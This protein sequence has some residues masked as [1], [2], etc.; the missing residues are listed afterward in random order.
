M[1]PPME[2]DPRL[3]NRALWL[4]MD[5]PGWPLIMTLAR[6]FPAAT[7]EELEAIQEEVKVSTGLAC[8]EIQRVIGENYGRECTTEACDSVRALLPWIE[9]GNLEL[10]VG[11]TIVNF[12]R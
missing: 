1:S 2:R 7:R 6:E 8:D 12:F 10:L 5:K 3:L 11:R 9:A 4:T